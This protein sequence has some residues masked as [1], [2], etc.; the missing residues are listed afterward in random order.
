[1]IVEA[2]SNTQKHFVN[3]NTPL[4]KAML[5]SAVGDTVGIVVNGGNP[6]V[7]KILKIQRQ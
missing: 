7:I 3:E 1:M 4:A 5:D 6:K 2:E